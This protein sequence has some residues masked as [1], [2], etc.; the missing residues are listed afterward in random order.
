MAVSQ[1]VQQWEDLR[2]RA[3]RLESDVDAKLISYN[4]IIT[5]KQASV[6]ISIPEKT[7]PQ[8]AGKQSSLPE[9]IEAC[10][11]QVKRRPARFNLESASLCLLHCNP[12]IF[13]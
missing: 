9:E 10:L 3:L 5:E 13:F 7:G 2:R 6:S 1:G 8:E 12:H 11:H 4:K